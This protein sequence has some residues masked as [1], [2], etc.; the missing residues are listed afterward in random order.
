MSETQGPITFERDGFRWHLNAVRGGDPGTRIEGGTPADLI[1]ALQ[2]NDALRVEV[3]KAVLPSVG[4]MTQ[5][6]A[7][8]MPTV[9]LPMCRFASYALRK[10]LG[11]TE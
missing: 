4:Q 1:A 11:V 9:S 8:A 3:L 6:L 5:I 2:Q 10:A 7:Q